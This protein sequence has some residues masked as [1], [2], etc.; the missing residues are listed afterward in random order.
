MADTLKVWFS[1]G[2]GDCVQFVHL[3]QLYRRRGWQVQVHYDG[4]KAGVFKVAGVT[5]IGKQTDVPHHGWWHPGDFNRPRLEDDSSGSKTGGGM[6]TAPL[7]NLG[8][9]RELWEELCSIELDA[10][11]LRTPEADAEAEEFLRG[12]PR[13]IIT[14]HTCGTTS[15]A[16]KNLSDQVVKELYK[17][18]LDGT[19]GSLVLL[20]WDHRVPKLPHER[21]RHIKD[22]WGHIDL[23]RLYCLLERSDLLIGVD[24]GPYHFAKLSTIPTIGVF[25]RHYPSCV[26]LPNSRAFNLARST[27]HKMCTIERRRRWNLG[28]YAREMPTAEDIAVHAIRAV[29]GP[30]Y[31]RDRKRMGRDLQLQ[32][33]VRDWCFGSTPLAIAARN[34]TMDVLLREATKRFMDP[35]IVET[36]CVRTKEDWGGAGN[37]TYI[38]GAYLEGLDAG[39]LTSVDNDRG[40]CEFAR[41]YTQPWHHRITIVEDD[42]VGWLKNNQVPIN[43]LYLDSMDA[44]LSGH[45][46]HALAEVQAAM[47]C[48]SSSS[49]VLIDDTV[50]RKGWHGKGALVVPFLQD[51]GWRIL[52]SGYQVLMTQE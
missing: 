35:T 37:S 39:H 24:S 43:V 10:S 26:S 1:H 6:E 41:A 36:G 11:P 42:S 28:E 48:L 22:D 49:L 51:H 31:L 9:K 4:N 19:D 20:D 17:R 47:P 30:R 2:L 38:F 14:L 15:A 7:P 40:H 16:E 8:N 29:Q 13:P 27:E 52:A 18:L 21:V 34:H 33:W 45:A 32:Q 25:H 46:E 23:E 44:D 5:Y 12:L 3:L 50:W